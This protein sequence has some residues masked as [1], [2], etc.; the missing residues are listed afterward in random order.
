[1]ALCRLYLRDTNLIDS[2]IIP[3]F[4][5]K[6]LYNEEH[7]FNILGRNAVVQKRPTKGI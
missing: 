3:E 2:H 5:Y 4:M 7:R 6:P 1:M